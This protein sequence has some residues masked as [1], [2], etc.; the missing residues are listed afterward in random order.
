MAIQELS[1][2]EASFM[3]NTC[4]SE[5]C[6]FQCPHGGKIAGIDLSKNPHDIGLAEIIADCLTQSLRHNPFIPIGFGNPI[7][8]FRIKAFHVCTSVETDVSGS[9]RIYFNAKIILYLLGL[10]VLYE[11]GCI[12]GGIRI[13][14]TVPAVVPNLFVVEIFCQSRS[15]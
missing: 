8:D 5:T 4:F 11:C 3:L 12:L 6:L 9:F 15:I 7:T 2:F 10:D 13:R 14:Q 1:I